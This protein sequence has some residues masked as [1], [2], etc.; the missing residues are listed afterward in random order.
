MARFANAGVLKQK[1]ASHRVRPFVVNVVYV[2]YV[3]YV[4]YVVYVDYE[5]HENYVSS[6]YFWNRV[7]IL[8]TAPAV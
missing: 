6:A 8:A 3:I 2:I 1:D 7:S 4:I 5:N